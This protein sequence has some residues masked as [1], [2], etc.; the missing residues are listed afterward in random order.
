MK[1]KSSFVSFLDTVSFHAPNQGVFVLSSSLGLAKCAADR[2]A[3]LEQGDPHQ[4]LL[5]WT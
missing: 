4:E 2:A 5:D 3:S 1:R